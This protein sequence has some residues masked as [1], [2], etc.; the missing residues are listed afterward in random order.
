M[1][2]TQHG[3][4]FILDSGACPSCGKK[5]L[6]RNDFDG[7]DMIKGVGFIKFGKS[8]IMVKCK[9]CKHFVIIPFDAIK[10]MQVPVK[11]AGK[12]YKMK[13]R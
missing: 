10:G 12:Q 13:V 11:F 1:S 8:Q 7:T 9:Q 3:E 6:Y 2:G 4:Q 5:L